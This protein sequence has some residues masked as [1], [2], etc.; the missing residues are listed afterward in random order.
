MPL[1][2]D[3]QQI[4][5]H[6]LNFVIL[7]AI[8]YFVLYKPVKKFMDQRTDYYRQM[9]EKTKS[10]LAESEK[11][12]AEY[13]QKLAAAEEEITSQKEKARKELEESNQVRIRAAEAEAAKI[14]AD[15]KET[16]QRERAQMLEA[17]KEDISD[18]VTA[19]AEKLMVG[20]STAQAY[21]AFL[22]KAEEGD[23]HE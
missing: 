8:L 10:N 14:I 9:E 22:K 11:T 12:K 7:F 19:A 18:M 17:A 6:L 13:S 3:W 15:A 2:I 23:G 4:L 1:N 21:D 5:L 20:G 16:V